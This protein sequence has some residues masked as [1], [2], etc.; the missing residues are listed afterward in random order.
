MIKL[1]HYMV[2]HNILIAP[3]VIYKKGYD[4]NDDWWSLGCLLYEF[5]SDFLPFNIPKGKRIN[6]RM[7]QPPL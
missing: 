1:L 6:L 3:E 2:P 4:K 7:F 5:L